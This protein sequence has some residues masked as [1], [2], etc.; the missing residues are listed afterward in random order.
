M[1]IGKSRCWVQRVRAEGDDG[2][3]TIMHPKQD[4]RCSLRLGVQ[5]VGVLQLFLSGLRHSLSSMPWV[6]T[7]QFSFPASDICRTDI[8]LIHPLSHPASPF[9]SLSASICAP[10][11]LF[12]MLLCHPSSIPPYHP[13]RSLCPQSVILYLILSFDKIA[14]LSLARLDCV[15]SL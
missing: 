5:V 13:C 1:T 8:S 6:S 11:R 2:E 9:L 14:V 12:W 7:F 4:D 3:N 10:L 15:L